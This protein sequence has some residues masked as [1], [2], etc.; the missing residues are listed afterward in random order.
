MKKNTVWKSLPLLMALVLASHPVW[1]ADAK[2]TP[3]S[4]PK[5]GAAGQSGEDI[6]YE[7]KLE[8]ARRAAEAQAKLASEAKLA[9]DQQ[10]AEEQ[11]EQRRKEMLADQ[12]KKKQQQEEARMREEQ[13]RQ[14]RM[15]EE[16]R[17]RAERERSC[18]IKPVMT[19]AEIDNCKKVWR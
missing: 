19:D 9:A 16:K 10:K 13:L 5:A 17:L 2:P 14:A 3:V 7:K 15:E 1:S 18:V 11:A 4:L 8:V 6:D 12:E